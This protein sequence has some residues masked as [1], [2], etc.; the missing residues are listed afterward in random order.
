MVVDNIH[1]LVA[2]N[3]KAGKDNKYAI[4][5]SMG[6][7]EFNLNEASDTLSA[8]ADE[9]LHRA[10]NSGRNNIMQAKNYSE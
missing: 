4:T 5:V 8:H 7:A 3:L 6:I 1:K 2:K 10:K 9:A